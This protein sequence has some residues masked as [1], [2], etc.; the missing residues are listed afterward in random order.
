MGGWGTSLPFAY[1]DVAS[2]HYG[3]VDHD[4]IMYEADAAKKSREEIEKRRLE[5]QEEIDRHEKELRVQE[6]ALKK[7]E[8]SLSA[9]EFD[10]KRSDFSTKVA[11]V[12]EKVAGRRVELEHLF[13][14]ARSQLMDFIVKIVTALAHEKRLS[15]VFPKGA[16]IYVNDELDMTQEV[17]KRIN[18]Q[19][20]QIQSTSLTKKES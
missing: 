20:P 2:F 1:A 8:K 7:A 16:L 5:F 11:K 3:V 6:D 13:N 17:L 14:D 4:R 10:Q 15:A 9:K 18:E 19:L 12:H